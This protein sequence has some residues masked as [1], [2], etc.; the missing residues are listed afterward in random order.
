MLNLI[1]APIGPDVS[2]ADYS[3]CRL[4]HF[5]YDVHDYGGPTNEG[6]FITALLF[7]AARISHL[8]LI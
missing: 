8:Q 1:W 4:P 5:V 3:R 2:E 6:S 7:F